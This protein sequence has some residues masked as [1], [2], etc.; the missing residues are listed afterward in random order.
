MY[1]IRIAACALVVGALVVACAEPT[2]TDPAETTSV[3]GPSF[4]WMNNPDNG[5]FK[6][7]RDA[8][9]WI[10]CWSDAENGL[11]VCQGTVPL[12][13][14]SEPDCGLQQDEA[15]ASYQD[16]GFYVGEVPESWLHAL[17][18][19]DAY[20]TIRDENTAGDCFGDALVAQGWGRMSSNDNDVFGTGD[21]ANANTWR[22]RGHGVLTAI[23]GSQV[24]YNGHWQ[25]VCWTTG[26]CELLSS[27]VDLH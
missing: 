6:I 11:R 13:G 17:M 9:D 16:V 25:I 15:P 3:A 8:F 5:N 12:G 1:L 26:A 24:M 19:G 7:Y 18:Q 22:Y 21:G 2:P 27:K 23:D 4:N 14:G 20:I 10:N